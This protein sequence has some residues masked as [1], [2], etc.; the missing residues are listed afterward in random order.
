MPSQSSEII[1]RAPPWDVREF[2][3]QQLDE[4][5]RGGRI[6]VM[7]S[8]LNEDGTVSDRVYEVL[9][10]TGADKSCISTRLVEEENLQAKESKE[11][12]QLADKRAGVVRSLG[13]VVNLSLTYFFVPS[14]Q[15]EPINRV[16]TYGVMDLSH[17]PYDIAV[18]LDLMQFLF[19]NGIPT[20]VYSRKKSEEKE[21]EE[22]DDRAHLRAL[23]SFSSSSPSSTTA[24]PDIIPLPN[25]GGARLVEGLQEM[26]GKINQEGAGS[27]PI[28]EQP[29]RVRVST[30]ESL[31]EQYAEKR[32]WLGKELAELLEVNSKIKGF[33]NLKESVVYLHV[34]Q[35]KRD[36][37][38]RRPYPIPHSLND[39]V[40]AVIQRW[41]EE[42]RIKL[43]PPNCPYN[44]PLVVA[45]KKDENGKMTGI[46]VCLDVRL[47]NLAL[48]LTDSFPLPRIEETLKTFGG[49]LIFGEFDLS[50]AYLQFL[51]HPDCQPYTAFTFEGKQYMFVGCPFGIKSLPGYYQRI[52]SIIMSELPF[53]KPYI[54]NLPFGSKNWNEHLIQAK[55]ILERLNKFNLKVKPKLNVGHSSMK[56][57][58][59][60]ISPDGVALDPDKVAAVRDWPLP[61]TGPE[62]E[63]FLGFIGYLSGNVRHFSDLTAPLQAVKHEKLIPYQQ[64]PQ[65]EEHFQATK[66]AIIRA[67]ALQYPDF[68][69]P[70]HLATDAS[71]TGVGGVLFQPSTKEEFITPHNIV[72]IFSHKLTVT[73][74]A[75]P[76][77]KKE[78]L[79]IVMSLRQ[80][81]LYM[82]GRADN[83]IHTDHKPLTYIQTSPRLSP[84][85]EAWFDTINNYSFEIIH[86]PGILHVVPDRLSR[87][88]SRIYA[89]ATMPWG[90]NK[91]GMIEAVD[92]RKDHDRAVLESI[93]D[94]SIRMLKKLDDGPRMRS[95]R[96]KND[97]EEKKE[98]ISVSAHVKPSLLPVPLQSTLA[99]SRGEGGK[100]EA[101]NSKDQLALIVEL[102]R[103]GK[104][105]PSTEKERRELVERYHDAAHFGRD[106]IYN[107]LYADGYWWIGMRPMIDEMLTNC[108]ACIRYVVTRAGYHPAQSISAL[109]PGD[110]WQM[111]CT[112]HMPKSDKGH[113]AMLV[114]ID[115]CTG[116]A[117]LLKPMK[118]IKAERVAR[119]LLKLIAL[120]GPPKILQSDNG[121]EFSND[122]IRALVRL[123]RIKHRY[124]SPYNPRADGKVERTIGTVSMMIKKMLHGTLSHWYLFLPFVQMQ[125]NDKI[126]SLTGSTPFAL[127]FSRKMN[128]LV[129]YKKEKKKK[130][131]KD[132]QTENKNEI[133]S[134]ST[135]DGSVDDEMISIDDWRIHQEKM[136]S[137]V[138]PAISDRVKLMKDAMTKR[139]DKYRRLLTESIPTGAVVMVR[140]PLRKD[141]F[142]P[143]YIGPYTVVRRIQNGSYVLKDQLNDLFDRH[144]P[145]DQLKLISKT[146]RTIDLDDTSAVYQIDYVADHREIDGQLEFLTYWKGYDD[147]T[148]VAENKFIDDNCIRKYWKKKDK[149][150]SE[151]KNNSNQS[152]LHVDWFSPLPEAEW[153]VE[154]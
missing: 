100:E 117:L 78:L 148:W 8:P 28:Y 99:S 112:S 17:E 36:K 12:F 147:P 40:R 91:K 6:W 35:A 150:N 137:L 140:D 23:S 82:W 116:T 144:V 142:E 56:I 120:V 2:S 125:F 133:T 151:E 114:V 81:H 89:D 90:V 26:Q 111:D 24:S 145:A 77:Y 79:G 44:N 73:E 139:L 97:E 20:G 31:G 113:T 50:E 52:M 49:C 58:G 121:P 126:S 48:L 86:R 107:K 72:S 32:A 54:D 70:F 152:F 34:D 122:V 96:L 4:L 43:A 45:A 63:S 119:K 108:D 80:F 109:L 103:R 85:L 110:H 11:E 41:L 94:E 101:S 123:M 46:R 18:G 38:F 98:K 141:K 13:E 5:M 129:D 65:L 118:D 22:N 64:N 71:L 37:L 15:L 124:I 87:M 95:L 51:L 75:Y 59:H 104:K 134:T 115:V 30:M 149:N 138:Y 84:S 16:H 88:Y 93:R 3:S 61:R 143:T 33:C 83:V 39:S 55:A 10:D 9:I 53:T 60:H 14:D 29:N 21:S 19:P 42:G 66:E 128:Q 102:E 154:N 1:A 136:I 127:F 105:A 27:L 67:P 132:G 25:D 62:M 74:R 106:A 146:P 92:E 76:A 130:E 7:A 68:N 135:D 131:V 57:L 47:L 153:G 69:R